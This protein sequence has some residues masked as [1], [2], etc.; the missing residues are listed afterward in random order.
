MVSRDGVLPVHR[1]GDGNPELFSELDDLGAGA[2]GADAAARD[3]DGFFRRR[4]QPGGLRHL[5][6]FGPGTVGRDSRELLFQDD[7]EI[8]LLL[9]NLAE[10]ACEPE[11]NRAGRAR[12]RSPERLTNEVGEALDTV[13]TGIELRDGVEHGD[14]LHFLIGV[15]VAVTGG[16]PAREGDDRRAGQP[17]VPKPCRKIGSPHDLGHADAGA[18]RCPGVAVGH[19]SRC[20]L[21]VS[22]DS[23]YARFPLVHLC[24]RVAQDS[25]D[26]K[27]M[28]YTV[29]LHG[30]REKLCARHFRHGILLSERLLPR[31]L[32]NEARG[33]NGCGVRSPT[34]G[35]VP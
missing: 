9:L 15:T 6:G 5:F 30:I 1:G 18:S 11:V 2:R 34:A 25:G 32:S 24:E 29:C 7:F 12:G 28:C 20:L 3:D 31:C 33:K 14:V 35:L 13:H 4:E 10:I 8:R 26:E 27:N 23:R 22:E 19:V 17:G 16:G 21:T